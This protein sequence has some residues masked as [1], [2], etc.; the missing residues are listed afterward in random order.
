MQVLQLIRMYLNTLYDPHLCKASFYITHNTGF[1]HFLPV[2][3]LNPPYPYILNPKSFDDKHIDVIIALFDL[4]LGYT[5]ILIL[6][7]S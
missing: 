7:I 4:G 6:F 2:S 3:N 1:H 5:N